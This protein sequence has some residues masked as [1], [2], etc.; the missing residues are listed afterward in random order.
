M[1]KKQPLSKLT[2]EL[3]IYP[4]LLKNALVKDKDAALN[5]PEVKAAA[6][7]AEEAMG[8][9][10]RILLRKSGTEPLLRV[11]AEASTEELCRRCVDSIIEAVGRAGLLIKVK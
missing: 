2:E 1:T 5:H 10:G 9:D 11:M 4:Q 7:A 8:G 3:K 6:K